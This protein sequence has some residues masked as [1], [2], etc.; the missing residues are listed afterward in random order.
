M[1][2]V[3]VDFKVKEDCV[4]SFKA[5]LLK[6]ARDSLDSEADCHQ[7]DVCSDPHDPT[8]F[9]LYELYTDQQSFQEHLASSHFLNFDKTVHDWIEEKSVRTL[10]RVPA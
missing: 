8:Q 3:I 10:K 7:F 9:T 6:Q 5:A 1:F 4:S 2:V